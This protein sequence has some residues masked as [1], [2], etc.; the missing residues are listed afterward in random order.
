[1]ESNKNIVISSINSLV[2]LTCVKTI[3]DN[4]I[5]CGDN[6]GK[7]L[8]FDVRSAKPIVKVLNSG[9]KSDVK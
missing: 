6:G 5:A 3:N 9:N 4:I 2:K 7:V 1:M 8:L